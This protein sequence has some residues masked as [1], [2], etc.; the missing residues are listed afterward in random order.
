VTHIITIKKVS[1]R[2]HQKCPREFTKTMSMKNHPKREILVDKNVHENSLILSTRICLLCPLEFF[3]PVPSK[4]ILKRSRIWI[5][6]NP[7][8]QTLFFY[9]VKVKMTQINYTISRNRLHKFSKLE[10]WLKLAWQGAKYKGKTLLIIEFFFTLH[11]H[12]PVLV[13]SIESETWSSYLSALL[14]CCKNS[15]FF[16]LRN[17]CVK[18]NFTSKC[19]YCETRFT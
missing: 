15:N 2:I 6:W 12:S 11:C 10:L 3:H 7:P 8:F 17:D 19:E 1:T 5:N 4:Y 14:N 9:L 13:L 18:R 16:K